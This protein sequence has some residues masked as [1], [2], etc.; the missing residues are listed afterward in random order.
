MHVCVMTIVYGAP[1]TRMFEDD[2][3]ALFIAGNL[4]MGSVRRTA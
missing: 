1:E 4:A 3:Q 2:A